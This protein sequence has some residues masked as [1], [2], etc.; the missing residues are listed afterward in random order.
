MP[1]S[2]TSSEATFYRTALLLGLIR[3]DIIHAWAERAIEREAN[4]HA[5]FIE[6]VGV[7]VGDLSEMRHAL[8]PLVIE[9]PPLEVLSAVIGLVQSQLAAGRRS[10]D[11]TVT[12]LRQLRS[13]VKLPKDLY[14]AINAALVA[15]AA[16]PD[17]H[18]IAEWLQQFEGRSI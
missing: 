15:H 2:P 6:I 16:D 5:A 9:P 14:D 7:P 4:P 12:V 3:G 1:A 11:D 18:N 10:V 17:T 8:W 13:M